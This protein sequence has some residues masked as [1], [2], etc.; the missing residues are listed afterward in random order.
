MFYLLETVEPA[1]YDCYDAK[2]VC[3][4]N[5][6]EARALANEQVGAEGKIWTDPLQVKCRR[7]R[8]SSEPFGVILASFNAG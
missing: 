5:E 6:I 2:V 4:S 3:A 1:D 7:L 8:H